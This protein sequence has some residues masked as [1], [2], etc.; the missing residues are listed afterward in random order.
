MN[1]TNNVSSVNSLSETCGLQ[2][3]YSNCDC[4][5]QSKPSELEN[6]VE[7]QQLQPD[8][9]ALT[10]VLPKHNIFEPTTEVYNITGYDMY[11]SDLKSCGGILVHTKKNLSVSKIDIDS[12]CSESVW[13]KIKVNKQ[14]KLIFGCIYPAQTVLKRTQNK[15]SQR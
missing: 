7:Q 12:E 5:S 10:E 6:Y 2:I 14:D 13:C 11:I 15:C 3:L 4:L 9:I 1:N 8:L